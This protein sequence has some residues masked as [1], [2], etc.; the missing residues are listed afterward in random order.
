[1][2]GFRRLFAIGLFGLCAG[3]ST[4][5]YAEPS[6]SAQDAARAAFSEGERAFAKGAYREATALFESAFGLVSHDAVRFNIAVCLERQG[7]YREAWIQYKAASESGMLD[8]QD[9]R[10]AAQAAERTRRELGTLLVVGTGVAPVSIDGETRCS[11]PC[12]LELDPRAYEI[13][14]GSNPARAVRIERG[15]EVRLEATRAEIAPVPAEAA[16]QTD[17]RSYAEIRRRPGPWGYVGMGLGALGTAGAIGFGL[18]TESLHDSYLSTPTEQI[19][20]SGVFSRTMTNVSIGVA[21]TGL[22][23]VL[24]DLFV[25]SRKTPRSTR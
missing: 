7:R 16:K 25:I 2:N 8:D 20:D 15:E 17:T 3:T 5:A 23:V 11:V 22:A 19:Y 12:R 14:I 1:M 18:R 24:V 10:R 4:L 13:V 6:P 9:R 21:V